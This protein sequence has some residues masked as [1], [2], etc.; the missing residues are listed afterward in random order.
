MDTVTISL[1]K[2]EKLKN[3][4]K[5][6]DKQLKEA[7]EAGNKHILESHEQLI[8]DMAKAS[9]TIHDLKQSLE[10]AAKMVAAQESEIGNLKRQV[11]DLENSVLLREQSRDHVMHNYDDLH[12]RVYNAG[13]I[14]RI[15]KLW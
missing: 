10:N 12:C 13:L 8:F 4:E 15:F 7:V 14:K 11:H 6:F 9:S 2:F 3:I 1:D 5:N